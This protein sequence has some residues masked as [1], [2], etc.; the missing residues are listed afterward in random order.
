[1]TARN[2][3]TFVCLLLFGLFSLFGSGQEGVRIDGRVQPLLDDFLAYCEKYGIEF[4]DKLFELKRIAVVNDLPTRQEALILGKVDRN[5]AGEAQSILINWVAMVD[6]AIFKVVAFHEFG[7][8]FLGYKHTCKDCDEIMAE[9][10]S[11]YFNIAQDW[12]TQVHHLFIN[13]PVFKKKY[14]Q[15]LASLE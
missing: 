4:H 15:T 3:K 5:E 10:N 6:P 11:S 9:V 1:M 14:G 13:S 2:H 8:H 7:H 12:E